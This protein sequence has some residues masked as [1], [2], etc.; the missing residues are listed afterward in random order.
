[1]T[2]ES[3]NARAS[4]ASPPLRSAL[5][6]FL[7]ADLWASLPLQLSR[8]MR[9]QLSLRVN[10]LR[11]D[12]ALAVFSSTRQA[13][14]EAIDL[15]TQFADEVGPTH[16]VQVGIGLDAGDAVPVKGGYRTGALNL[17]ARLQSL[18]TGEVFASETVIPLARN[19][20][21]LRFV[22]RGAVTLKGLAAPIRV[23]QIAHCRGRYASGRS[24]GLKM[25]RF[26]RLPGVVPGVWCGAGLR[27]TMVG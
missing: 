10:E 21:G 25:V 15:R 3:P 11:T 17:T 18:D 24:A 13:L 8:E 6:T 2:I 22:D 23:F 27:G 19:T 16:A 14:R 26:R 4:P 9:K 1:M 7:I 5:L 12:E 20:E